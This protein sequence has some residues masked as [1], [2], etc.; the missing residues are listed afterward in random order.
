MKRGGAQ[1]LREL[2][3]G[4]HPGQ[5][6]GELHWL[7]LTR[8]LDTIAEGYDVR[9]DYDIPAKPGRRPS[10]RGLQK[11]IVLHYLALRADEPGGIA[12]EHLGA[13]ALAWGRRD[14]RV[15]KLV[16]KY[17]RQLQP[18][19]A[20]IGVEAILESASLMQPI[21]KRLTPNPR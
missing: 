10:T 12:K 2:R 14:T 4:L 8:I 6:L 19:V 11:W 15:G 18:L 16:S 13:V 1:R 5:P 7:E 20:S 17:R 21:Y 3:A 9:D